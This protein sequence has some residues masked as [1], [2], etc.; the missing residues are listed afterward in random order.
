M[1]YSLL[2][3]L[4]F[5][6]SGMVN[7]Q[8]HLQFTTTQFGTISDSIGSGIVLKDS[9]YNS[10]SS[11]FTGNVVA[12]V[13]I[14]STVYASPVFFDSL[15]YRGTINSLTTPATSDS[16][17]FHIQFVPGLFQI[18]PN[19]VVIW[20]VYNG[21]QAGPNDTIRL[22]V[23]VYSTGITESELARAYVWESPGSLHIYFGEAEAH[24]KEVSI[25]D[26]TGRQLY[27]NTAEVPLNIPTS[28]WQ[29]GI[30][31]CELATYSGQKRI[32]KII[33]GN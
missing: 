22:T 13:R 25:Y 15:L 11:N 31:F 5:A 8:V 16:F 30:Y 3:V 9:I 26:L 29:K 12:Q 33:T 21:G 20:P 17:S 19:V 23:N 32:F 2:F 10:G 7:A 24:I 27:I 4:S 28:G 14:D 1:R 18:G 6:L